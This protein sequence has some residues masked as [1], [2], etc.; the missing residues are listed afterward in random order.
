MDG[1]FIAVIKN[2]ANFA[3]IYTQIYVVPVPKIFEYKNE[4]A[5]P[6][7]SSLA[8][9]ITPL[10]QLHLVAIHHNSVPQHEANWKV[11]ESKSRSNQSRKVRAP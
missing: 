6:I 11:G 8:Q 7:F 10:I 9:T 1:Y 4:K 2:V 3:N 5:P